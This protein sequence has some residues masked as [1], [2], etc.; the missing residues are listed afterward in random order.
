[1]S[2][3]NPLSSP[4]SPPENWG[5]TKADPDALF[6]SEVWFHTKA[7]SELLK[8]YEGMHVAILDEQIIDGD[9][10]FDAFARRIEASSNTIAMN[11]LLFRYIP[12]E[13]E[14]LSRY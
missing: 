6:L 11:R 12:A 14:A 13:D 1:M 2:T 4:I 8:K 3:S 10:D 7:P 9:R 5:W